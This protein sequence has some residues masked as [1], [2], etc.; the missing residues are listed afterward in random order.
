LLDPM[1]RDWPRAFYRQGD[2][3]QSFAESQ[4]WQGT[5]TEHHLTRAA[6]LAA[7]DNNRQTLRA[8]H[9]L[10]GEWRLEQGDWQQASDAFHEALRM[11][12][13]RRLPDP[14]AEAGL[15]LAKLNLG[16]FPDTE[17]ARQEAERLSAQRDPHHR[18]LAHLWH[19]L[20][21]HPQTRHHALAAYRG[22]WGQGEPW[23]FRYE[24]DK[25]AQL[26]R[27]MQVP[28][29]DLPP[30]DPA[31]DPPFPWEAKVRAAI[32]RLRGEQGNR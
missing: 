12:R 25:S 21:D 23:V 24:L 11:A 9:R 22:A 27:E 30:Y 8:I 20:G 28:I 13:E 2:A 32:E 7:R 5:L 17:S 31:A 3:E 6:E 26:L 18:Y 16:R 4:L 29:P 19:A 15:A 1:G 14:T 10:R